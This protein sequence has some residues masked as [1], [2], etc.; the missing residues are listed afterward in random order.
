M[1][2]TV[3][4]VDGEVALAES[5]R[6]L[7]A[8]AIVIGSGFFVVGLTNPGNL[9]GLALKTLLKDGL[10]LNAQGVASFGLVSGLA[11]YFKPIAGIFTDAVPLFGTRRR[12]YLL[13]A[14]VLGALSM[15]ALGLA[16]HSYAAVLGLAI[17]VNACLVVCS[18]SLGGYLVETGNRTGSTGRL[19]AVR[20]FGETSVQFIAGPIGG[21]LATLAFIWAMGASALAMLAV[22]PIV[23]FF[24]RE[25]RSPGHGAEVFRVAGNQI[26][27]VLKS[28]KLWWA[29]V[30]LGLIN[31]CPGFVTP[32]FFFQRDTL[33]FSLPFIGL[34]G[35]ASAIGALLAAFLYGALALR[36]SMRGLLVLGVALGALTALGYL[37][38]RTPF[39]AGVVE[40]V[41]GFGLGMANIA[42]IHLAV[43]G[44]PAGAEGLGFSL[45][46]SVANLASSVADV[47]G[48]YLVDHHWSFANLVL[49]NAS[50][51]AAVLIVVP[52][53]PKS[54]TSSTDGAAAT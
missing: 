28:K 49:L 50:T 32:L 26:K 6:G 22:V 40:A 53:L 19:T 51:T 14:M 36:M 45:I 25:P 4:A 42:T 43:Q 1:A 21:M 10:H 38:Y 5:E 44:T 8:A 3:T 33:K 2:E 48:S 24:M 46:V 47:L 7:V 29:S 18:T 54:L 39:E 11:W 9:A 16:P 30:F 37:F 41:Y 52:L 13:V 17:A 12:S 15:I 34:L 31:F 20:R 23:W 35:V 27:S